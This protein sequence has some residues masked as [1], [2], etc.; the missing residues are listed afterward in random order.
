MPPRFR[1][2]FW[3]LLPLI[4]AACTAPAVS[5][6]QA[7]LSPDPAAQARIDM[8]G[9]DLVG[10]DG[11]FIK[12]GYDLALL[13]REHEAHLRSATAETE[14]FAP[15][16]PRLRVADG[17]VAIDAVASGD[18]ETLLADLHR[19]GLVDE[20]RFG[21]R[22]SGRLPIAAIDELAGLDSLQSAR[23]VLVVTR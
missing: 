18:P 9:P 16:D 5:G 3:L 19:L 23:P 14:P 11:P 21:R 1:V 6:A 15:S 22:V 12:V 17:L 4:L 2:S 13:F 7:D 8:T 10:R 20:T